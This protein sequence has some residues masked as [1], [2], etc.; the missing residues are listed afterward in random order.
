MIPVGP[1][2]YQVQLVMDARQTSS[3]LKLKPDYV[4]L[5]DE[6]LSTYE[7]QDG[8]FITTTIRVQNMTD[9][10]NARNAST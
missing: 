9:L 4:K 10:R 2:G 8:K 7:N 3:I 1:A 5:T 6:N